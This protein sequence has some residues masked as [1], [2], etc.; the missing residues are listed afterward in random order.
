MSTKQHKIIFYRICSGTPHFNAVFLDTS[1]WF[2]KVKLNALFPFHWE[3]S[4]IPPSHII[5]AISKKNQVCSPWWEGPASFLLHKEG[6][7]TNSV[8]ISKQPHLWDEC[9]GTFSFFLCF[10]LHNIISQWKG[11]EW[12]WVSGFPR[13]LWFINISLIVDA[14]ILN[15]EFE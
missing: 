1:D 4:T 11:L 6:I 10:L 13:A 3:K 9:M 14:F 7:Q 2:F 15:I 5:F 12:K 8:D